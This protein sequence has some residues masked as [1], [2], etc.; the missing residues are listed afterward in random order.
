MPGTTITISGD[1]N[2]SKMVVGS[3]NVANLNTKVGALETTTNQLLTQQLTITDK[4]DALSVIQTL[5]DDPNYFCYFNPATGVSGKTASEIKSINQVISNN[6]TSQNVPLPS[7]LNAFFANGSNIYECV[8]YPKEAVTLDSSNNF[9]SYVH[10]SNLTVSLPAPYDVD[11]SGNSLK[12]YRAA[13]QYMNFPNDISKQYFESNAPLSREET[14]L[15]AGSGATSMVRPFVK[16]TGTLDTLLNGYTL[17]SCVCRVDNLESVNKKVNNLE[18]SMNLVETRVTKLE[19]KYPSGTYYF[20]TPAGFPVNW[21]FSI[22]GGHHVTELD[23]NNQDIHTGPIKYSITNE[24]LINTNF[25]DYYSDITTNWKKMA[26]SRFVYN[27]SNNTVNYNDLDNN[28]YQGDATDY[29]IISESPNATLIKYM[30]Y[31]VSNGVYTI[32]SLGEQGDNYASNYWPNAMFQ[33]RKFLVLGAVNAYITLP[34]FNLLR[35][36]R[37]LGVLDNSNGEYV[38]SHIHGNGPNDLYNEVGTGPSGERYTIS[39]GPSTHHHSDKTNPITSSLNDISY[40]ALIDSSNDGLIMNEDYPENMLLYL[41][42]NSGEF[43]RNMYHYSD[44]NRRVYN[45]SDFSVILSTFGIT[46]VS[47]NILHDFVNEYLIFTESVGENKIKIKMFG[48]FSVPTINGRDV[49]SVLNGLGKIGLGVSEETRAQSSQNYPPTK[50][51]STTDITGFNASLWSDSF[52][53]DSSANSYVNWRS[54][55]VDMEDIQD[56]QNYPVRILNGPNPPTIGSADLRTWAR[57]VL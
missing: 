3:V 40:S 48:R 27:K 56:L 39:E 29:K 21:T 4:K 18:T 33:E 35:K 20:N 6:L 25:S 15:F 16:N 54:W 26:I 37:Q 19:S 8:C 23:V 42:D 55:E 1:S 31:D 57:S 24:G 52:G 41:Q 51:V 45:F 28:I 43:N 50:K 13:F 44:A 9:D 49:F 10:F 12:G 46:G 47:G 36:I 2:D 34:S 11:D 7:K 30:N 5:I 53:N 32:S 38:V 14:V 22:S 17:N